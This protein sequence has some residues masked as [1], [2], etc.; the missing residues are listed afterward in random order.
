MKLRDVFLRGLTLICASLFWVTW[1]ANPAVGQAVTDGLVSYWSFDEGTVQDDTVEDV[2]GAH[3]GTIIGA[4]NVVEGQ[5]GDGLEL[6]GTADHVRV[7]GFDISPGVYPEITVM[8]WVFPTS[9][10]T[11][12]Q[13]DRRFLFGHDNGDWDRGV[14]MQ[15]SAWRVG[16]GPDGADYWNTGAT[17]D[18][19]TWQHVAV[20][21]NADTILFFK[22]AVEIDYGNPGL[23]AAGNNFLL[24]G[25]HPSQARFFQGIIDEIY[26][27]ERS[28]TSDE[29]ETNMEA[30]GLAVQP[31][32]KLTTTWGN[33]KAS[34]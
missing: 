34:R 25:T 33:V 1:Q 6:N 20:V 7:E 31:V 5:V 4:P 19:N 18:V 22:D 23:L 29:L 32:S 8:A 10:G 9:D 28:L 13:A 16:T 26:V 21:Y 11:G 27:Y 17:V 15:E 14:L 2:W 12:G 3:A 24:I 30:Q